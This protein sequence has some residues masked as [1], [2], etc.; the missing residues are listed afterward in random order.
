[1]VEPDTVIIH[2]IFGTYEGAFCVQI[3]VAFGL[4]LGRIMDG[5]FYLATIGPIW[6]L[7]PGPI[8]QWP[9]WPWS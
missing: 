1:M 4:P 3:V 5:G 2:L 9:H 8:P 6:L 7:A